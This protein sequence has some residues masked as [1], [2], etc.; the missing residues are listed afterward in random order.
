[1]LDLELCG[2]GCGVAGAGSELVLGDPR[3]RLACALDLLAD[4]RAQGAWAEA[5]LALG[6]R[7]FLRVPRGWAIE[8]EPSGSN[9]PWVLLLSHT[10]PPVNFRTFFPQ[11][12]RTCSC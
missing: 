1:V 9:T 2:S 7:R 11:G 10:K 8:R 12:R 3:E 5:N 6:S 4:M